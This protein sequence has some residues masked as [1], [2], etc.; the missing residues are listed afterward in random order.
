MAKR[1]TRPQKQRINEELKKPFNRDNIDLKNSSSET[2]LIHKTKNLSDDP[3]G[4]AMI[5]SQLDSRDYS[6]T[7]S[8]LDIHSFQ[9]SLIDKYRELATDSEVSNG[10]DIIINEMIYTIEE[11]KFKIDIKEE[12][13]KIKELISKSFFN[14]L[15]LLNIK[16]NIFNICRQAYIDGQ[17]N[18]ALVY[19]EGRVKEGIKE[20]F[21]L[22]PH[23]LYF[24]KNDSIWKYQDDQ[25][26]NNLYIPQDD[27]KLERYTESELV[28]IDFGLYT[29]TTNDLK[30]TF[31]LNL[32]Y[33]EGTFKNA[34]MLQTLENMLVPLRYSRSVSRR[35]FNID[36]ADLPP[37]QAKELMDK[38]RTEFRYKKTYDTATGTIKNIKATQPLV[39]DYWMSNRSG[40]KGTTVDTMDEKGSIIDMADIEYTAKKLYSSM[41]I[42]T[43]RNPYATEQTSFSFDDT[44]VTQEELSFY[45]FISRLRIPIIKLIKEILRRQ[46]IAIGSMTDTEWKEFEKKISISFSNDSIFLE[47]M[48]ASLFL[49]NVENFVG[50][51]DLIGETISLQTAVGHTFGW[52]SEQLDSELKLM[53][54]ERENPLY[55]HFYKRDESADRDWAL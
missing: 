2:D 33:L 31:Q 50:L 13:D 5:I 44:S 3:F 22:E 46:L 34:N 10:I 55:K 32:S 36:V 42:P 48:K 25:S 7:D 4:G 28:H 19:Q 16:E 6:F 41:K 35:M 47:N 54:K 37:K 8:S 52:S 14:V 43:S 11:E 49:K 21:I 20:A 38:I 39:E 51:K 15:N 30:T 26:F 12:N 17:L 27:T 18:V 9:N 23:G 40:S 24:D 1:R 53:L 45:I 29:K